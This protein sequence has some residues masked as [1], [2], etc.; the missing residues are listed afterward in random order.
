MHAIPRFA[1]A[2]GAAA[3]FLALLGGCATA[4]PAGSDGT[5]APEANSNPD[6]GDDTE[7]E[8]EDDTEEPVETNEVRLTW[9]ETGG[10]SSATVE[11]PDGL[12]YF[13]SF[14]VDVDEADTAVVQS[15]ALDTS[16]EFSVDNDGCTGATVTADEPCAITLVLDVGSTGT[17][18]ATIRVTTEGGSEASIPVVID[19]VDE[20]AD[21][22]SGS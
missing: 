6:S 20:I 12:P 18:Q 5:S 8:G 19:V 2:A 10:A 4:D 3:L 14:Q 1:A 11:F 22:E 16:G 15:V 7:G 21:D 17:Y 13:A 9:V